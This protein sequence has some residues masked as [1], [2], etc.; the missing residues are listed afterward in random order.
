[1]TFLFFLNNKINNNFNNKKK[2][3]ANFIKLE[4][5]LFA[6]LCLVSSE[7]AGWWQEHL[8][9]CRMIV[10]R[11]GIS[12]QHNILV[13]QLTE[14]YQRAVAKGD[15]TAVHKRVVAAYH[16]SDHGPQKV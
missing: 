1:M 15:A 9:G 5:R 10:L 11:G 13:V 12:Q 2:A 4:Q 14:R 3:I 8:D 6:L 16:T 7:F